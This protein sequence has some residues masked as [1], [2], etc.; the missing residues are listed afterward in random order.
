VTLTP[1][2]VGMIEDDDSAARAWLELEHERGNP[3][4]PRHRVSE[5]RK[6]TERL[7]SDWPNARRHAAVASEQQLGGLPPRLK[8]TR[9]AH[10][11]REGVTAKSAAHQ[12][13][14]RPSSTGDASRRSASGG[15]RP[16]RPRRMPSVP[17]GDVAE[18][19]APVAVSY[20]RLAWQ[21]AGWAV[22]L[23]LLYL[24]LTS[25]EK[26]AAGQSAI[27]LIARGITT[28]VE[29]IVSPLADPLSPPR[30]PAPPAASGAP[31]PDTSAGAVLGGTARPIGGLPPTTRSTP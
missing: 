17:V 12:R 9:D 23:S 4:I 15:T 5:N 31:A 1:D 7:E 29:T 16:A 2:E 14:A 22:G 27:E 24:L 13:R 10:R 19:V 30:R 20:G 26:A 25:S 3:G 18:A 21:A 11:R 28:T 6:A 8:R